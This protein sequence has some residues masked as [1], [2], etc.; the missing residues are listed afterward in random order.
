MVKFFKVASANIALALHELPLAGP[1]GT[2]AESSADGL[3]PRI[4]D[5][6]AASQLI[7]A[8]RFSLRFPEAPAEA[9]QRMQKIV[10][11]IG[12][13]HDATRAATMK[14]ISAEVQEESSGREAPRRG[15]D[16][17]IRP[18]DQEAHWAMSRNLRD[19]QNHALGPAELTANAADQGNAKKSFLAQKPW[20]GRNR[21]QGA[22]NQ[23]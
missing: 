4:A 10:A 21:E 14:F 11:A 7:D 8:G 6:G 23:Q 2:S 13:A 3:D 15:V 19:A 17:V 22:Q 1:L 16:Y 12:R 5:L 20:A 18:A 9:R